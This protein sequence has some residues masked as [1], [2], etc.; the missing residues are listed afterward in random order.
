M[1]E[2]MEVGKDAKECFAEMGKYRRMQDRLWCQMMQLDSP[3]IKK[4]MKELRNRYCK[5]TFHEIVRVSY[6]QSE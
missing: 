4:S 3:E 1:L 5:T 2:T 6:A